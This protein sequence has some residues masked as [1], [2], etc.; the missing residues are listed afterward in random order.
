MSSRSSVIRIQTRGFSDMHDITPLAAEFLSSSTVQTGLFCAFVPGATAGITTIENEEGALRDLTEAIERMAPR[1]IHY[2]HDTRW[3][4]GNGFSH[5]RAALLGPSLC[6]PVAD[7][8]LRLG[9][10]Q[11][12]VLVD[13]DNRPRNREV[14]FEIVGE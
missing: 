14:I 7:G 5:V 8:K 3:G 2:E 4:D 6:V 1:D 10:W 13:F 11:Q 9:T 12:I